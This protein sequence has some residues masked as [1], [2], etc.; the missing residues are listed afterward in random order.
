VN[1]SKVNYLTDFISVTAIDELPDD[2][3]S[4]TFFKF[5][6]RNTLFGSSYNPF[7]KLYLA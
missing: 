2:A 6:L 7:S 1:A 4:P 5:S 3:F